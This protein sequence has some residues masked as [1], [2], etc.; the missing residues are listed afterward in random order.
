MSKFKVGD[1]VKLYEKFYGIEMTF[2]G[3]VTSAGPD[4]GLIRIDNSGH[5]HCFYWCSTNRRIVKLKPKKEEFTI[6]L[7]KYLT[8]DVSQAIVTRAYEGTAHGYIAVCGLL[9]D[10]TWTLDGRSVYLDRR[11]SDLVER[12]GD[13]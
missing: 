13:L 9:F 5:T 3:T 7:G 2:K 8:R 1:R 12:I 11:R 10:H 4:S 6:T